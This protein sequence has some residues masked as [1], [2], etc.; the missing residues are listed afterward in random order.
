MEE[1]KKEEKKKEV[2]SMA[3]NKVQLTDAGVK[4]NFPSL[5]EKSSESEKDRIFYP[6]LYL[7][8]KEA[9]DLKGAEAGD[10]VTLVVKAYIS[11][12]SLNDRVDDKEGKCEN[13][14][15][16]IKQIGV[17][18]KIK[19]IWLVDHKIDYNYK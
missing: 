6:S 19:K 10:E 17:I 11:S 7:S 9:P 2:L 14:S 16:D 15:I 1:K 8:T 5:M 12:H 13:F 18:K 4:H 3:I